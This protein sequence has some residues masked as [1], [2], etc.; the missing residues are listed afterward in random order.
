MP[1]F[2]DDPKDLSSQAVPP[3]PAEAPRRPSGPRRGPLSWLGAGL[4]AGAFVGFGVGALAGAARIRADYRRP[5]QT[6]PVYADSSPKAGTTV[7][8]EPGRR[9]APHT[10]VLSP[11]A[12]PVARDALRTMTAADKVIVTVGSVGRGDSGAELHLSLQNRADCIVTGVEGVAYGFDPEGQATAMNASGEHYVAFASKEL[13]LPP[14]K[15]SIESWPLRH[16]RIANVALA[17]VDRVTCEDGRQ[18]GR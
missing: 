15:T 18:F 10:K 13:R 5:Y 9:P 8:G 1:S 11:L 4:L 17:Q 3:E 16:A 6:V 14:G 12:L 2:L 7:S